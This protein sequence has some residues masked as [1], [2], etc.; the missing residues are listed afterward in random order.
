MGVGVGAGVGT[1]VGAG[2][3]GS[4]GGGVSLGWTLGSSDG[5]AD[6]DAGG[7]GTAAIS[8]PDGDGMMNEG[9]MPLASGVGS[10]MQLGAALGP[11]PVPPTMAPQERPYGA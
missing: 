7:H 6:C 1:G 11:Q 10:G 3:G 8:E 2:V 5:L 4:V 9:T